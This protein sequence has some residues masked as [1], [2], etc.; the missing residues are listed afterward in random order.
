MATRTFVAQRS[1][2][3]VY[4]VE[5]RGVHHGLSLGKPI[6]LALKQAQFESNFMFFAI[7]EADQDFEIF[8]VTLDW[9]Q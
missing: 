1:D 3:Q 6:T 7:P 2:Q 5:T 8:R 4:I 9:S